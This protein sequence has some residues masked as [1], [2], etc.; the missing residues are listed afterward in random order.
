[1][2]KRKDLTLSEKQELLKKYDSLPKCTQREVAIKLQISQPLLNKLLN[3]CRLEIETVSV[4]NGSK[5]RKR[6]R[7]GKDEDVEKVLKKWFVEVRDKN[8]PINAPMLKLKSESLA[9]K[10]GKSDFEETD[11]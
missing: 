11:G 7:C 6:K 2:N 8:A 4:E 10:L 5:S 3:K 9:A 1:M